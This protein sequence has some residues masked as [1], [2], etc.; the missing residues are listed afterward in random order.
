MSSNRIIEN[1]MV[2]LIALSVKMCLCCV[3]EFDMGI[4]YLV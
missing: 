3:A 4:S 1:I 2:M